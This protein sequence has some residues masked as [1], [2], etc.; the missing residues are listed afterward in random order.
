[1]ID[2]GNLSSLEFRRGDLPPPPKK[3]VIFRF[4]GK[5]IRPIVQNKIE[6]FPY[7]LLE[8]NLAVGLF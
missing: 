3:K 1:M 7:T 4:S 5:K 8:R 6:V 2:S